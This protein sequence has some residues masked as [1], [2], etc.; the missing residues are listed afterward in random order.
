M[1]ALRVVPQLKMTEEKSMVLFYVE[2]T[3]ISSVTKKKNVHENHNELKKVI[4]KIKS[5][6]MTRPQQWVVCS[7]LS[8]FIITG[9]AASVV[10]VFSSGEGY[11]CIR[12]PYILQDGD[13]TLYALVYSF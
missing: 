5:V 1:C 12:I 10:D 7:L 8:L 11:M 9:Y 6:N 3:P 4:W 2:I 13:T